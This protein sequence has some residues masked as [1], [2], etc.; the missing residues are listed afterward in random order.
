MKS[1]YRTSD[2]YFKQYNDYY[3]Q[4]QVDSIFLNAGNVKYQGT[5]TKF[6]DKANLKQ[7]LV[8]YLGN[9]HGMIVKDGNAQFARIPSARQQLAELEANHQRYREHQKN[10]GFETADYSNKELDT[11]LKLE[12]LISVMEGEV[13]AIEKRLATFEEKVKV[14]DDSQVLCW[15]L[16][17]TVRQKGGFPVEIDGQ[18]V[19]K[20][21][22]DYCISDTRS[23]YNS[24]KLSQYRK[25]CT[26]WREDQKRKQKEKLLKVQE[27]CRA[28]GLPVVSHLG[29]T[30]FLRVSKTNL[31]PFP[32]WAKEQD[33]S[34]PKLIRTK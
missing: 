19:S 3:T 17:G 24:L 4:Y 13:E 8:S 6:W 25:L 31:P 18:N 10:L 30:T 29:A 28:K 2:P 20:V 11:K 12:A 27:E 21:G 33:S 9:N 26:I 5:N 14:V 23:P 7:E 1:K 34:S 16:Q 32:E 22:D 15:G